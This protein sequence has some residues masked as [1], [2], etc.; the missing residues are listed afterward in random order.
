V[1]LEIGDRPLGGGAVEPWYRNSLPEMA[2]DDESTLEISNRVAARA[3][4]Q[5]EGLRNSSN[6]CNS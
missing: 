5:D 1:A 2:G 3:G 6:S 4:L